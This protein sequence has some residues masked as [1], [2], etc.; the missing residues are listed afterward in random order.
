ML[1]I[2]NLT[3]D[4]DGTAAV[5]NLSLRIRAGEL[6]GFLGPNGAGKTTTIKMICGLLRPS[7]GTV[8]VGGFDISTQA[9]KAKALIGLIPDAPVLYKKL[10]AREFVRFVGELYSVDSETIAR[11]TADLLDLLDMSEAADDLIETYSHGMKQKT[12]IMAALIHDPDLVVLDEPTVGLDPRSARIVKDVLKA[13]CTKG[14]TVFMSTHILEIAE[15]MCDRV[16]IINQ[17]RLVALGSIDDLRA[18][19][20]AGLMSL[21]DVFLELTGGPE[22]QE[23]IKYLEK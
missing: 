11:R 19:S 6:F 2:V 13:L 20:Q 14:K 17:G 12:M 5:N 15:R 22:E 3:K 10:T 23:V 9:L 4:Y 1:N 16:G 18:K 8:E 7:A 21:E